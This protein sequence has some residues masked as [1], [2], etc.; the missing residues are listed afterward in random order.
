MSDTAI[1]MRRQKGGARVV[2]PLPVAVVGRT[3]A[4]YVIVERTRRYRVLREAVH[5]KN[6]RVTA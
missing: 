4:G 3:P 6:L 2:T 1:W 5:P